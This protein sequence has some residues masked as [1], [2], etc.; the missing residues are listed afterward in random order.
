M[1]DKRL[2]RFNDLDYDEVDHNNFIQ[3]L[4]LGPMKLSTTTEVVSERVSTN[5][6]GVATNATLLM[7]I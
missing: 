3:E 7:I 5:L 2:R 6:C 4:L 1:S